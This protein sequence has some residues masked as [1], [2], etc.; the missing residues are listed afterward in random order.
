[1]SDVKFKLNGEE[2]P[3]PSLASLSFQDAIVINRVT[4]LDLASFHTAPV[5]TRIAGQIAVALGRA[6]ADWSTQK[7]VESVLW[8]DMSGFQ[9]SGVEE[10]DDG[11]LPVSESETSDETATPVFTDSASGSNELSV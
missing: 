9:F 10:P 7:V 5:E 11:P 1:M 8:S 6:H 2:L 3:F 4:G